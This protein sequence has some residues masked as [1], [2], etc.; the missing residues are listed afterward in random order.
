[1]A[2]PTVVAIP[3]GA[4]PDMDIFLVA[5]DPF[6]VGYPCLPWRHHPAAA[7]APARASLPHFVAIRVWILRNSIG[8]SPAD[9]A[10]ARLHS[11]LTIAFNAAAW[12]RWLTELAASSLLDKAPFDRVR[13]SDAAMELLT[14]AN[15]NQLDI[16]AADYLAVETWLTP[17]TPAVAGRRAGGGYPARAAIP[18]G[19]PMPGPAELAF[20]ELCKID[21]LAD[22]GLPCPL[23]ALGRLS[24]MLGP[25]STRASRTDV[26]SSVRITAVSLR[27]Y[28]ARALGLESSAAATAASDPPLA[29]S[30]FEHVLAAYDA[31][32]DVLSPKTIT[33]TALRSEALDAFRFVQGSDSDRNGIVTRRLRFIEDRHPRKYICW[34]DYGPSCLTLS[35][36]WAR[37]PLGES[38]VGLWA[39]LTVAPKSPP[40]LA[41][42]AA[43]P[44]SCHPRHALM[45]GWRRHRAGGARTRGVCTARPCSFR[46][47]APV[48]ELRRPGGSRTHS[49]DSYAARAG[50]ARHGG[51]PGLCPWHL[52]PL[53]PSRA[54]ISK[55][56]SRRD[57]DA[58]ETNDPPF[59]RGTGSKPSPQGGVLSWLILQS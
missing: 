47:A 56:A 6:V 2:A 38:K 34:P 1:M 25:V 59:E 10:T 54:E 36:S 13:D 5:T 37:S 53:A 57:G 41:W 49:L 24:G 51:P 11:V 30:I 7:G 19:P 14:L 12:S 40:W 29:L 42:R 21:R 52:P 9:M 4:T 28:L 55:E 8:P 26:L 50:K 3:G 46:T 48:H 15:P 39:H 44:M 27:S 23:L 35:H 22:T 20:L 45:V 31:L 32:T 17:G 33:E 16:L 58:F 18:A 43:L